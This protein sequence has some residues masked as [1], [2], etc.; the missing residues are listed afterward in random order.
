MTDPRTTLTFPPGGLPIS[1]PWNVPKQPG[2]G[3]ILPPNV[4]AGGPIGRSLF[5]PLPEDSPIPTAT[6]FNILGSIQGTGIVAAKT[7]I[8]GATFNVPE[9]SL[10]V[11]RNVTIYV[12]NMLA[13]TSISWFL[14]IDNAGG[15]QGFNPLTMFPRVASSVS[16]S[17]DA[18]IRL[19]G[20]CVVSM[21]YTQADGGIN[22][23]GG[24]FGGWI[25]PVTADQRWK[26]TG[27]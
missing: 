22:V 2:R 24:S 23:I 9:G 8:T 14:Q 4:G 18:K 6:E 16:N 26:T 10:G 7:L 20:P 13:T 21:F 1:E 27:E 11:I 5:L 3:V 25:W 19:T 17:F 15:P 12:T